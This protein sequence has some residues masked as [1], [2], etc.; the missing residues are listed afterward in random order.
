M[1]KFLDKQEIKELK[2]KYPKGTRVEAVYISD[3]I[4]QRVEGGEKGTVEFVDNA[5]GIHINWDKSG[6]SVLL[7]G[8]N[9]CKLI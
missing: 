9:N 8:K 3:N 6:R 7:H 1:G 4:N 5:G 2:K